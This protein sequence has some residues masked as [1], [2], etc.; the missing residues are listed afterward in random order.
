[1]TAANNSHPG[2]SSIV[3]GHIDLDTF[4]SIQILPNERRVKR[5][6][7][8][9][10]VRNKALEPLTTRS[11]GMQFDKLL[12]VNDVIFS[13]KDVADLLFATN[14]GPDGKTQY[15]AA[16][17]MDFINSFK[18]YDTFATRD[19]EGHGAGVP[20]FP[21]FTGADQGISRKDVLSGT[22]A[23][24]VKSCWGG[25]VAFEAKWFDR[26]AAAE[27]ADDG[28]NSTGMESLSFRAS[29]ELFWDA[30]ECC[31]IHADLAAMASLHPESWEVRRELDTGIYINPYIRVAYDT[32][33]FAWLGFTR[34]FER[35]Y[36]IPQSIVNWLAG[37]PPFQPR[38]TAIPGQE[39]EHRE[40]I[41]DGPQPGKRG[42]IQRDD[43]LMT[44]IRFSGH[45]E[46]NN[47]IAKPGGFCGNRQ[48]L[49]LKKQWQP[50]E[51]IWERI[52]P[53]PGA[54]DR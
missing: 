16:C 24:R 28:E 49:V 37:R 20:F 29:D 33:S 6:A 19:S 7:Y 8:L 15:H 5:I 45:W 51:R 18:F 12:F 27:V 41:Y 23:V 40:W 53:P 26:E 52:G 38:R 9:A 42:L 44:Q 17:A 43:D 48:L 11:S 13:P 4:P 1:M 3:S 10:E 32:S 21:W 39:A 14:I 50:G 35:L 47:R 22:D 30:S 46:S 54:N 36:T 25:M 34:R 31:L 2:N